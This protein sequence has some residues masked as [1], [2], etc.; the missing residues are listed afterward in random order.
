MAGRRQAL[1]G[2]APVVADV[3]RG[4]TLERRQAG[5]RVGAVRLNEAAHHGQRVLLRGPF[6][7]RYRV[8]DSRLASLAVDDEAGIRRYQTGFKRQLAVRLDLLHQGFQTLKAR[9]LPV[10]SIPPMGAIYLT[11]RI[12]PFGRRTPEGAELLTNRDVRRYVLETAGIGIVPFGAFGSTVDEGWF[13][14][15]VGAVSEAEIEAAL[16]RLEEALRRLT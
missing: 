7:S 2:Q 13:R 3:T 8:D 1:E 14:L 11:V 6:A 10:E 5:D 9:G 4:A 16:P 12:N 15:S